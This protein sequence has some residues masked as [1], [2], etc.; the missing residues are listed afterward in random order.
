MKFYAHISLSGAVVFQAWQL[1]PYFDPREGSWQFLLAWKRQYD[2]SED[3]RHLDLRCWMILAADCMNSITELLGITDDGSHKGYYSMAKQ[4]SNFEVLNQLARIWH[5]S[6]HVPETKMLR[7]VVMMVA[8]MTMIGTTTMTTMVI[9]MF[10]VRLLGNYAVSLVT[11]GQFWKSLG[12][13]RAFG[14]DEMHL[15]DVSGAYFD[16]GNHTE[17]VRLRWH[18]VRDPSGHNPTRVLIREVAE[19]PNLRLVPHLGYVSLFPFMM[20]IIP[21]V[22]ICSVFSLYMKRN[23][24]H[25]PPYWRGPIWINMNY[26]I[27]SALH[28]YSREDGPYKDRAGAVYQELRQN[29]IRN[30]VS[31][32]FQTGYLWEQYE[33]KGKGKGAH[34]FTG[35]IGI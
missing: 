8:M 10:V 24:E 4:L 3:E 21:P 31:N 12:H 34:P 2:Y 15:D 18:E 29:V 13:P 20:R 16:F 1:T 17:K 27:L 26:M 14:G 5:S 30:V 9:S 33:E 28:Y 7:K 23:T 25:D 35:L 19:Q 22:S 11:F 32:Y 6:I